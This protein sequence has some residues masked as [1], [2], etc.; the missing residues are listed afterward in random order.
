MLA[1]HASLE[2][3]D[4]MS[5]RLRLLQYR[6]ITAAAAAAAAADPAETDKGR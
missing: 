4:S 6:N 2:H 3:I 1:T 5:S